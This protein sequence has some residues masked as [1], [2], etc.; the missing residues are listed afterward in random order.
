MKVQSYTEHAA[1]LFDYRRW[2]VGSG[3]RSKPLELE[4][5]REQGRTLAAKMRGIDDREAAAAEVGKLIHVEA[6]QLPVLAEGEYFWHQLE[7]LEVETLDGTPLGTVDHLFETGANDVLVVT[8]EKET[9]VPYVSG[10]VREI[11]LEAGVM[12]VDWDPEF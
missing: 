12:R 10:V 5:G 6:E 8:G 11:D 4:S 7:G 9:L 3:E 2:I 1:G